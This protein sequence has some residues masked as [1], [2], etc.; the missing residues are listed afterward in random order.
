M[1]K[2]KSFKE[3]EIGGYIRN[4]QSQIDFVALSDCFQDSDRLSTVV[5]VTVVNESKQSDFFD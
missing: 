4:L 5:T 2:R 1:T 3:N